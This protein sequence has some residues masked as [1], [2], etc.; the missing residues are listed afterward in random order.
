[1]IVYQAPPSCPVAMYRHPIVGKI[2]SEA[3][4]SSPVA[5]CLHHISEKQFDRVV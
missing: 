1:M 5:T 3:Q 2:R 4:S